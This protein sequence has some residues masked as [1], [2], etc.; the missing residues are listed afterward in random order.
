[1]DTVYGFRGQ[2][3]KNSRKTFKLYALIIV[4]LLTGATNILALEGLETQDVIQAIERH[5]S[6][7]SVPSV[8]YVDNSTQ[9]VA[10]EDA[11]YSL[12][13]L[14]CHVHDSLG[15][16][17]HVSTAKSHEARG[18]VEVKVKILRSMLEK[19]SVKAETS[20]TA[21]Q[22]ETLFAKISSQIDDIPIAKCSNTNAVDPGWDIITANRLKLGRN[23]FRSLEGSFNL[24]KSTG[25][26]GLLRRNQ[27]I[28]KLWYQMLLDRIHHLIPRPTKWSKSDVINI[29]DICLFTHTD[30][31]SLGV[32]I[33]KLGRVVELPSKN[34][35]VLEYASNT[36]SG[37]YGLLKLKQIVRSPRNI[38]IISAAGDVNLNSRKYFEQLK[39]N[40]S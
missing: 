12:R 32:D 3:F 25:I 28:Q 6:R 21:V 18:R 30:N 4:C 24:Q 10:L 23:N 14:K 33:W 39:G 37:N 38:S 16:K 26:T 9:L 8:I 20:M 35:V 13:D 11:K 36:T 17:V 22:W 5:S 19:L 2:S 15:L 31:P 40:Q 34:K 1:M 7:H 29:D 27:Q